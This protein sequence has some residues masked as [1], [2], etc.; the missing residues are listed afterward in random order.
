MRLVRGVLALMVLAPV[1]AFGALTMAC[2]ANWFPKCDDPKHPCPPVEPDY[3]PS[4]RFKALDA[5]IEAA[6][7]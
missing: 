6:R 7:D 4:P 3:P 5:A 1:V 2:G